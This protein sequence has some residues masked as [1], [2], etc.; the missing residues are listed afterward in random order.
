[1]ISAYYYLKVVVSMYMW[2]SGREPI[3]SRVPAMAAIA[4][5]IAVVGVLGLGIFPGGWVDL[6]RSSTAGLQALP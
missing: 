6:A 1:V 3:R 2:A 4:L 5:L